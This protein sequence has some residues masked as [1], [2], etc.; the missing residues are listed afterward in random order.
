MGESDT[1]VLM[2]PLKFMTHFEYTQFETPSNMVYSMINPDEHD[3]LLVDPAFRL[4]R[5]KQL[6]EKFKV[7]VGSLQEIEKEFEANN[8]PAIRTPTN[9]V[10][11]ETL[12]EAEKAIAKLDRQF[13]KLRRFE[14]RK[15][16][17]PANHERR[18]ARMLQRKSE[19]WDNQYPVYYN[20]L[21]EE[22]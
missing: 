17:D 2:S 14:A 12:I 18:E 15:F 6:E 1:T 16:L 21:T 22:E 7:Y 3:R 20:G 8:G 9:K 13:N 4:E 19:R 5:T 11:Y 10:D